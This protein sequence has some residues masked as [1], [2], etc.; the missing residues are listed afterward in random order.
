MFSEPIWWEPVPCWELPLRA[1]TEE[2]MAALW[3]EAQEEVQWLPLPFASP[4]YH[5][6]LAG[7]GPTSEREAEKCGTLQRRAEPGMHGKDT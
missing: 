6:C 5:R 2:G 3:D 7:G 4:V 1:G